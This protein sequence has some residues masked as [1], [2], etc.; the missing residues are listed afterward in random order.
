GFG[1]ALYFDQ[2]CVTAT[3]IVKTNTQAGALWN[4][5]FEYTQ[6]GTVLG[7]VDNW[8]ALGDAG[9]VYDTYAHSGANALRIY[10]PENLAA[11]SWNATPG[12]KYSSSGYA[13]TPSADELTGVADDLQALVVMEF[14]NATGGVLVSYASDPFTTANPADVWTQLVAIGV[15]PK[16]AVTGRTVVGLVGPTN[17]FSGSVWFDDIAQS[18]VWTQAPVTSL[19]G[20][21]GFD[22]GPPGNIYTLYASNDL[23][24]WRWAGGDNAG[25][26]ARDYKKNEEQA[27]VLTSPLNFAMQDFDA[28]T[29]TSTTGNLLSNPGFE[30]GAGDGGTPDSWSVAGSCGQHSWAYETGTNGMAFWSWTDGNWGFFWQGASVDS[31]DGEIFTFT[32]RGLAQSNFTSS[33]SEA[34]V[35]MEFWK[36]GEGSPRR[37]VTNNIYAELQANKETWHTYTM[38]VTN[39]DDEI[40]RVTPI[41][42]YGQASNTGG[43]QAVKWDNA[44]LVQSHAAPAFVAEGYL[45]TPSSAKFNTDGSS[46]GQLE[47]TFYFDGSTNPATEFTATSAHFGAD[48]P[49]DT[50]IYFA[51]TGSVPAA[52]VVTGRISCAIMSTD[53]GNDLDLSGVIWFDQFSVTRTGGGQQEYTP[54]QQWQIANFGS[55]SAPNSAPGE[56]Y[57]GDTF[58]NWSEFIADTDPTDDDSFLAATGESQASGTQMVLR[59]PSAAGRYY[60][61]RA[62]T[63]LTQLLSGTYTVLSNNIVATPPE[64]VYTDSPPA[65]VSARYYRILVNTNQF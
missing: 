44:S 6:A 11:Q 49:A 47:L 59:W 14:L 21:A 12:Y 52:S 5:G 50:W 30:I 3:N 45:F 24:A 57:D 15:A 2:L 55:L 19:I 18:V 23:P 32:I 41:V 29:V 60:A 33:G 34:Y 39:T 42:G 51:V 13:F 8:E 48:R 64:N 16:G 63:N 56:D 26:V 25:F 43:D 37:I 38:I 10:F 1:G 36:D 35:K 54:Y 17:S 65:G 61:V 22:D 40:D 58:N 27:L 62:N 46:W 53:P 9:G 20:N 7:Y 28:S 31:S 4:P